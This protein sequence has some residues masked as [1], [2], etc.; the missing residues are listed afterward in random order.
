V[1]VALAAT[2]R[3]GTAAVRAVSVGDLRR[4][5]A[6]PGDQRRIWPGRPERHASRVALPGGAVR[7]RRRRHVRG[8]RS[9]RPPALLAAA[10]QAGGIGSTTRNGRTSSNCRTRSTSAALA[11]R[12]RTSCRLL[13]NRAAGRGP[14]AHAVWRLTSRRFSNDAPAELALE[15]TDDSRHRALRRTYRVQTSDTGTGIDVAHVHH[16]GDG[17]QRTSYGATTTQHRRSAHRGRAR[18]RPS[19][20]AEV[21]VPRSRARRP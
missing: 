19:R 14:A 11:C 16:D 20:P 12:S 4:E 21:P 2:D 18:D 1:S 6:L 15:Q 7:A 17:L 5:R 3:H 8:S 10:G 9:A 13:A